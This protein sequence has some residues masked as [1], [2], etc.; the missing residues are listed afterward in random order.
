[1]SIQLPNKSNK[2]AQRDDM[3]QMCLGESSSIYVM[4]YMY[5]WPYGEDAKGKRASEISFCIRVSFWRAQMPSPISIPIT[6]SWVYWK[7]FFFWY[8]SSSLHVSLSPAPFVFLF[9][10]SI[11]CT[12]KDKKQ[13][14]F[15]RRRNNNNHQTSKK[16]SQGRKKNLQNGKHERSRK[17]EREKKT[18]K[19]NGVAATVTGDIYSDACTTNVMVYVGCVWR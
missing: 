9:F 2:R 3:R 16:E 10:F 17:R 1:M 18:R 7:Y 5:V 6:L 19:K 12:H 11:P 8:F 14:F 13:S 4:L 15:V